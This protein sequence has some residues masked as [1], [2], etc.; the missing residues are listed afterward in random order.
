MVSLLATGR[1]YF[2]RYA[3][4]PEVRYAFEAAAA[5]LA[6]D[7]NT[8]LGAGW[9]G[10]GMVAPSTSP[11]ADRQVYVDRRVWSEWPSTDFL[12]SASERITVLPSDSP[13]SPS[14]PGMLVAWPHDSLDAYV[15]ALPP[16]SRITTQVGPLTRGDLEE[17]TY[18]SYVSYTFTPASRPP[19]NT[20][21]IAH[22]DDRIALSDYAIEKSDRAWEVT[23]EWISLGRPLE[24]YTVSVHLID[25]GKTVAQDDGEPG[26]GYYPTGLWRPGDLI[27]DEHILEVGEGKLE[28]ARLLV[29]L[30]VWPT[31]EQLEARDPDGTSLG[32]QVPL[33]VSGDPPS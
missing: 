12:V 21:P 23:L 9:T 19:T 4:R 28:D 7:V 29:S 11:R 22:F 31:M 5:D 6:V 18:V 27:V 2:L 20:K 10:G 14:T 13:P 15:S 17:A 1:D 16:N 24:D 3:V 8:F 26:D 32:T 30:Y 33:P 25:D